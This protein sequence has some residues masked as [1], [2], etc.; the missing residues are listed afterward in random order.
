MIDHVVRDPARMFA[1]PRVHVEHRADGV[2]ILRSGV[3]LPER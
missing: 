2:R 1:E 3:P